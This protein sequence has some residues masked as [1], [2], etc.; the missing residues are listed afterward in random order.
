MKKKV[1]SAERRSPILHDGS[2]DGEKLAHIITVL[3]EGDWFPYLFSVL[4]ESSYEFE[5]KS[6]ILYTFFCSNKNQNENF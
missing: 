5:K 3:S 1:V 6:P 2:F 4:K